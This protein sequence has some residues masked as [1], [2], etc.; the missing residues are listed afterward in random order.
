MTATPEQIAAA[1]RMIEKKIAQ[2]GVSYV[3][4]IGEYEGKEVFKLYF[5]LIDGF[6]VPKVGWQSLLCLPQLIQK[7]SCASQMQT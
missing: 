1:K 2:P 7:A 3:R 5:E 4:H 6:I